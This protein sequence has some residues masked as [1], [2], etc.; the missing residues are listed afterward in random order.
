MALLLCYTVQSDV[1]TIIAY[2]NELSQQQRASS[3]YTLRTIRIHCSYCT[4]WIIANNA[5]QSCGQ[6]HQQAL[7]AGQACALRLVAQQVGTI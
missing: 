6:R 7:A 5:P 4:G 2:Y 3:N 1:I